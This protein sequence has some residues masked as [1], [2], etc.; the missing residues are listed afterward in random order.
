MM[1]GGGS[2]GVVDDWSGSCGEVTEPIVSLNMCQ[3]T[4]LKRWELVHEK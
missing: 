4:S 2:G 1:I 3:M